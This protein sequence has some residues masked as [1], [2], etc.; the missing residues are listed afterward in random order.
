MVTRNSPGPAPVVFQTVDFEQRLDKFLADKG[1]MYGDSG[2]A[3]AVATQRVRYRIRNPSGSGKNVVLVRA[4]ARS[5]VNQ[6]VG[7]TTPVSPALAVLASALT[8]GLKRVGQ[9]ASIASAT[10]TNA[11]VAGITVDGGEFFLQ[12]NVLAVE[13]LGIVLEPNS[14]VDFEF[15]ATAITDLDDLWLEGYEE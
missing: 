10:F 5:N 6:I 9:P 1:Y 15:S 13:L 14:S 3:P 8:T 4:V 12:A 11:Q 7:Y 2:N